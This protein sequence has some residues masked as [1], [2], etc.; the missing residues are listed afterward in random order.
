MH[1]SFCVLLGCFV[2]HTSSFQLDASRSLRLC[3]SATAPLRG[4]PLAGSVEYKTDLREATRLTFRLHC[5][6]RRRTASPSAHSLT[7]KQINLASSLTE[8]STQ[9]G[10][11]RHISSVLQPP[12]VI[13]NAISRSHALKGT[14]NIIS[15]SHPAHV[16][17]QSGGSVLQLSSAVNKSSSTCSCKLHLKNICYRHVML[18]IGLQVSGASCTV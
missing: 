11:V 5:R 12:C 18:D 1:R 6:K 3:Q 10:R 13:H 7:S 15:V 17:Q 14:E 2:S 8:A 16:K 9:G 4:L